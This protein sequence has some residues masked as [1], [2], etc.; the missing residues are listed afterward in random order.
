MVDKNRT[1]IEFRDLKAREWLDALAAQR[2]LPRCVLARR[3]F[4]IGWALGQAF[5]QLLDAKE[6]HEKF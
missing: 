4:A 3:V 1:I 6:R 5:P 2:G